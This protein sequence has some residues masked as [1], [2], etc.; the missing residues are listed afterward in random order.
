MTLAYRKGTKNKADPLGR[1][2]NFKSQPSLPLLWDGDVSSHG[3]HPRV[4]SQLPKNHDVPMTSPN[5]NA[6]LHSLNVDVTTVCLHPVLNVNI[7]RHALQLRFVLLSRLRR[8]KIT[9]R[10]STSFTSLLCASSRYIVDEGNIC[11]S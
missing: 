1:R 7:L 11:F 9:M 10:S 4:Q 8:H 2:A 6:H 3:L 5:E